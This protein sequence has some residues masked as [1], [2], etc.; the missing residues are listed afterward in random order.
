MPNALVGRLIRRLGIC[1]FALV[2]ARATP[3]RA[4]LPAGDIVATA[5]ISAGD[6]G[7]V[8]I[9][10]TTGNRSILS[11][12]SHG[13]GMPFSQPVGVSVTANGDLLVT[14]MG[15][16]N[17]P[18]PVDDVTSQPPPTPARVYLVDPSTG[19]RTV[20]SQDS[21]TGIT[22][23][24][25]AI[26]SGPMFNGPAVARQVGDQILVT[27]GQLGAARL[28]TIDPNTGN[29]AFVSG[30]GVGIGPGLFSP[31]GIQVSGTT[32]FVPDLSAG[33][34]SVNLTTGNRTLISGSVAGSGPAVNAAADLAPYAGQLFVSAGNTADLSTFGI[35]R[36]DPA[37]GS[38]TVVSDSTV[39]TG[40][41]WSAG[42]FTVAMEP[43]GT[44]LATS[45]SLSSAELFAV[46]STTGNRTI[47]SD[48]THGAG[49]TL[50]SLID[51]T[52]VRLPGDANGDGVVNGL[53]INAV[54]T[55]WNHTGYFLTG[56]TNG[57]GV[58]NG[59]DINAIAMHWQQHDIGIGGLGG[60]AGGAV[61]APEPA[62]FIMA[63]FA[64]LALSL[65]R[66]AR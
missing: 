2:V 37:T 5:N 18:M 25:A 3:A 55:Q 53:D 35:Y 11:D 28:M 43:G 34:F 65:S 6:T 4:A 58:V 50:T 22:T 10:P 32:A 49:P 17:G 66:R 19:N 29:R 60:G 56:D 54:A 51:V 21:M 61:A 9:D 31:G 41:I 7:L 27:D 59:V 30:G 47:L 42:T 39:G 44:L 52:V 38:R 33:L 62:T 1:L 63:A 40:P 46:D 23:P 57:D 45:G 36:I 14:D 24:Y 26:G 8:L 15:A 48:A 64:G 12:N 13:A 16:G 20:L